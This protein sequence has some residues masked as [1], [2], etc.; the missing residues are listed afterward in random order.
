MSNRLR[1]SRRATLVAAATAGLALAAPGAALASP[2]HHGGG[3]HHGGN[4]TVDQV[5]LF[6]DLSGEA[7]QVDPN[8]INPWG[9]AFTSASGVWISDQGTDLAQAV[10]L[11]PGQSTGAIAGVDVAFPGS[12][13]PVGG[14]TGQVANASTGFVLKD[15]KPASFIFDTLDG[16]IDAWDG[17][18]GVKGAV[19]TEVTSPAP[20]AYTGLA[21][22]STRQGEE[23]FAADYGTGDVE[24]FNSAFQPV[25][26]APWQFQDPWLAKQGYRPF[27][28]QELDGYIFVT[29]DT[30]DPTPPKGDG[31]EGLGEGIGAADEYTTGGRLIARITGGPLDAPWGLA[32][33]PS[34]W[35]RAAGS[36]LVGNFGDGKI[37]IFAKEGD[38]FAR[39]ATGQVL[40]APGQPFAE[41]GLWAL[42]S[43]GTASNQGGT[44]ALWFSAGIAAAQGGPTEQHG[45]VGVLRP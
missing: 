20:A 26:L 3:Y 13:S 23:L 24:V 44:D 32:I 18:D 22:A 41:P 1:L 27:N 15:G 30:L 31:P 37:N 7:A 5:N 36:L 34:G 9:L 10:T 25:K 19:E 11:T 14:P 16:H 43:G 40:V 2:A 6:S 39:H 45:L 35:G 42:L 17:G 12:A 4:V 38:H 21:I 29:Y 33:A 8:L 28:T